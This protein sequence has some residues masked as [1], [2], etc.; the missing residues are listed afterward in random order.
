MLSPFFGNY[1]IYKKETIMS[2]QEN[3]TVYFDRNFIF[4]TENVIFLYIRSFVILISTI[5]IHIPTIFFR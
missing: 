2:N 3:K 5:T 1:A 4:Y